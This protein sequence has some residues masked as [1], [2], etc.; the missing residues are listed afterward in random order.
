VDGVLREHS[1]M[2]RWMHAPVVSR[3]KVL[4]GLDIAQRRVPQDGRL[5]VSLRERRCDVRVSTLPTQWGE[6]VVLRLLGSTAIPSLDALG[7][8]RDGVSVLEHAVAQPQGLILVTGPTGSGKSTT[9]Y[10]ML[11]R[12]RSTGVNI[13]TIED[14]IEYRVPGVNQVQ[15]DERSGLTFARCLRAVL[16]QDPDVILVG[17]IR[18]AETAEVAIQAALT[19]HL[20]LSTVHTNSAVAT[21][22]RLL[23]LGVRPL[24]VT[25][26]INLVIAQRLVRR[27]CEGCRAAYI[28][29]DEARR[30]VDVEA[31]GEYYRGEGCSACGQTGYAGRVGIFELLRLTPAIK[32]LVRRRAS[33][34]ELAAAAGSAGTRFLLEDA[35]HQVRAGVTTVEEVVRVMRFDPP[36]GFP[37]T[38]LSARPNSAAR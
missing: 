22:D 12:R 26:A 35:A 1:T 14:P 23:D 10:S 2:P 7:L 17:E 9:L 38:S 20:V 31:A 11:A 16:R 8:S 27:I 4:A 33:E 15:I 13:V 30:C 32:D 24:L 29:S 25:A 21:I 28:P 3:V 5:T 36:A 34:S 19:G 6:K 18:D 37:T